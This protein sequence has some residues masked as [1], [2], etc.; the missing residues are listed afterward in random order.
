M[1]NRGRENMALHIIDSQIYGRDFA[2]PEI[3]KIFE[4]ESIVQ[5]WLDFEVALAE[6]QAELGFIPKEAAKEIKAKGSLSFVK[7]ARVAEIYAQTMLS[8][9]AMIRAFKEVCA[10]NAGEYIHYGATTQD[11]FDTTLAVRLKKTLDIFTEDL[12]AIRGHLNRLADQ[13][14][15]TVMA[16]ITH[17]QQALPVTFGFT[18]AIWSDM[19]GK[20]IDRLQEARKRILV[21]TVS[22][23]VGNFSSFHFLFGEKCYEMQK[24]VLERFG[25]EVPKINIQPQIERLTEFL[26]ILA[27]MSVTFEKIADEIFLFQ[28]NEFAQ[29]EEPFDTEKQI[30][31]ST[32]P[33]KRN[34]NRCEMIKALAKKIRSNCAGFAEIYM[35]EYR[36]HSPFYME[37][38]TIPETVIL[39]STMLQQAKFVYQG[40]TVKKE[41]MR[42][43]LD[44][45]QG[46]IMAE[47]LM[48]ALAKKTGKKETG[49][50]LVH[51][52]AM[53]AF[54]KG[55]PFGEYIEN[56]PEI[57]KYF[58][59][60]EIQRLLQP[61]NYLGLNDRLIDEVIGRKAK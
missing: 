28:R 24:R 21:G 7:V 36:D 3:R 46:L 34:P 26:Q 16:G 6:V 61:E 20:H 48:L 43:N 55:K 8:S 54:E 42:R 25:L 39:A 53:E 33:Q 17:G 50:G 38:F 35:R 22:G 60:E 31:S 47:T 19:V 13:H 51:K 57:R 30:S 32:M 45:S 29:L 11:I 49:F 23:A 5:D 2:T 1:E 12:K 9:V 41:N 40:L 15:H 10:N 58:S 14:R 27:L 37:D 4:E 44:I 59:Q 18:A 56:F 52:A